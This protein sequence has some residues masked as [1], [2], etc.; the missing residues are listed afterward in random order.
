M[1]VNVL[2]QPVAGYTI[3]PQTHVGPVELRIAD[4]ERSLHFYQTVIGLQVLNRS[5]DHA[6][7][8]VAG[9]ALLVLRVLSGA[10][11]VPD[12]ATGLYHFAI[13]VPSAADLGHALRRMIVANIAVGQGDHLVSEALYLSD[14]DGNGIEVYRDRPRDTWR[15]HNGTVEMATDPVDLHAL[16]A[17][18]E[19]EGGSATALPAGTTM[20]HVHLK[21]ADIA[22]AHAFFVDTLGFSVTARMSSALFVSAGGYHHHFGL[23]TWHS[24]GAAPAG[25]DA[26]GLISYTVV[27]GDAEVRDQVLGRLQSAQITYTHEDD[28]TVFL[29]PWNNRVVLV[30]EPALN[31]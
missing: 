31:V 17:A 5:A 20:G 21:V 12:R 7:L 23:N 8:G 2:K 14:P 15:W 13:L 1:S 28:Q 27:V 6:L 22:Q 11:P 24:R 4:L 16:L 26:S 25:A 29:D 10:R 18:A 3:D 19:R 9:K 30:V